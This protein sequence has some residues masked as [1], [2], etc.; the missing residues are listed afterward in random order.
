M[1]VLITGGSGQDGIFLVDKI[2]KDTNFDIYVCTRNKKFFDFNKLKYLKNNEDLRRLKLIE[3]NYLN[4]EDVLDIF[5]NVHPNYIYNLMGPSSVNL[6]NSNPE[7]MNHI[8]TSSFNNIINALIKTNNFCSFYQASSSEM[9]GYDAEFPFDEH[10]KFKPNSH[11]AKSKYSLHLKCLDLKDKYEWNIVSGIMFNHESEFR[12]SSF[13]IMKL[14][15]KV[16]DINNGNSSIL[17]LPS[18]AIK[19]DWTYAKEMSEAITKLTF[20]NL[21]GSY[22]IGSGKSH[23]IGEIAD[24]L[25]KK[26]NLDY[27]DF[28]KENNSYM[29]DGEPLEVVSNPLK[30]KNDTGWVSKLTI[31]E[32]LD[33]MYEYRINKI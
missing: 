8:A 29:R 14:V 9:Y 17:E 12:T 32:I 5:T 11:Y 28:V 3:I 7:E 6:F 13:L 26:V 27:R 20:D 25:F 2:L 33:K 15:E 19:R 10:S 21:N 23:S 4:F 1:K 30:M 16:I 22:V 24:Y 31:F 18:L